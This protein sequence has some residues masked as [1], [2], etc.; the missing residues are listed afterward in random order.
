M[1]DDY[2]TLKTLDFNL[3]IIGSYDKITSFLA[4]SKRMGEF[5]ELGFY[6]LNFLII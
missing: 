1:V 2:C 3:I 4:K 6:F 5:E